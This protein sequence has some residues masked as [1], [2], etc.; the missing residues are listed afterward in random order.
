MSICEWRISSAR[1]ASR[2]AP[3]DEQRSQ[4]PAAAAAAAVPVGHVPC[5]L[6]VDARRTRRVAADEWICSRGADEQACADR[7][8]CSLNAV[9]LSNRTI[10]TRVYKLESSTQFRSF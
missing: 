1:P 7:A 2:R 10:S 3:V 6:W 8:C 9:Y 4:A 5:C